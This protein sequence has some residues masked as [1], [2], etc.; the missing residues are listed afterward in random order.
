MV[1]PA[2]KGE[3]PAASP[4]FS[5]LAISQSAPFTR[6]ARETMKMIIQSMS[7]LVFIIF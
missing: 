4:I 5:A 3:S 6:T 1:T 7:V 2:T